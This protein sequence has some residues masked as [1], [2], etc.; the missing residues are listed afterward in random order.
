[1]GGRC[2]EL[3]G[4]RCV[5]QPEESAEILSPIDTPSQQ[6]PCPFRPAPSPNA[7]PH[8]LPFAFE[9]ADRSIKHWQRGVTPR[10]KKRKARRRRRLPFL[11]AP[12]TCS[13][14]SPSAPLPRPSFAPGRTLHRQ[15]NQLLQ[16]I[17]PAA[18]PPSLRPPPLP[19]LAQPIRNQ[20]V[21]AALPGGCTARGP[22]ARALLL[23]CL[24]FFRRQRRLCGGPPPAPRF[25]PLEP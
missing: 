11:P 20:P 25:V 13:G 24:A 7:T 4:R 16:P 10:K 19:R 9:Q 1:M 18:L 12:P 8:S 6:Q 15:R 14:P 2:K 17:N 22:H 3:L 5:P 23:F 21:A